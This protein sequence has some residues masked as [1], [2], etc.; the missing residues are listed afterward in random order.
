[1]LLHIFQFLSHACLAPDKS[2]SEQY[3][4]FVISA[5]ACPG[6]WKCLKANLLCK[7]FLEHFIF[8]HHYYFTLCYAL[9][10]SS[11]WMILY[12]YLLQAEQLGQFV[13]WMCKCL[14]C[15]GSKDVIGWLM[16][17]QQI[18]TLQLGS[19]RPSQWHIKL[20]WCSDMVSP[21]LP[22]LLLCCRHHGC[23]KV[24]GNDRII[25]T[26]WMSHQAASITL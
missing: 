6:R 19:Y 26:A 13:V 22:R 9:C 24:R 8:I 16:L 12:L 4:W 23:W 11:T 14:V 15:I 18:T 10:Y 21:V 20:Q 2:Y 17:I 3:H 7:F 1:M 25:W 5:L